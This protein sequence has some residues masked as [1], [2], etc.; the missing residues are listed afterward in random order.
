MGNEV[1]KC[2]TVGGVE[3]WSVRM[4]ARELDMSEMYVGR[5]LADEKI[6]GRKID[7]FRYVEK[8]DALRWAEKRT[9]GGGGGGAI[10]WIVKMTAEMAAELESK[11]V[12]LKKQS[13]Y[14]KEGWS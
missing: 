3:Y 1:K 4:A 14:M 8:A 5:L 12:V 6:A 9:S 7:G 13:E 11:G 2:V 10:N